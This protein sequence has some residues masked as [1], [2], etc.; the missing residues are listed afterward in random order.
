[1]RAEIVQLFLSGFFLAICVYSLLKFFSQSFDKV[2]LYYALVNFFCFLGQSVY[3]HLP[4]FESSLLPWCRDNKEYCA[5]FSDITIVFNVLF[6]RKI[7]TL[8]ISSNKL[9][10]VTNVYIAFHIV[11]TVI[12]H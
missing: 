9:Y 8:K 5:I 10:R 6:L 3:Y 4:S 11:A 12:I 7:M 2:Y 1:M